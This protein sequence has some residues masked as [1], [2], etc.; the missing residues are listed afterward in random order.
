MDAVTKLFEKIIDPDLLVK[1]INISAVGLISVEKEKMILKYEQLDIFTNPDTLQIEEKARKKEERE[2]SSLQQ[3]VLNIKEKY[4]KNAILRGMNLE[5]G[6][7]T[8]ERN[9]QIGGHHE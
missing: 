2:E 4:G 5:S 9:R 7:T 1:R 6:S 8:I 3:A